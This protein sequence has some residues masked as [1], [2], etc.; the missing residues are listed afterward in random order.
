MFMRDPKK[1]GASGSVS[2]G[3]EEA[4]GFRPG[5]MSEPSFRC[6]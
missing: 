5:P 4:K 1:A 3:S 2:Y 6:R